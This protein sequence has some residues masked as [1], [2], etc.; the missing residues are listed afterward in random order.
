MPKRKF[1][2]SRNAEDSLCINCGEFDVCP[3]MYAFGYSIHS[4]GIRQI[5][6]QS[7]NGS[8]ESSQKGYEVFEDNKVLYVHIQEVRLVGDHWVF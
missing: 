7:R 8:L 4:W 5:F 1:G 6:K 2:N 3:S